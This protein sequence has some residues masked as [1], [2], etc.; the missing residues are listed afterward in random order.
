MNP[1]N[2][3]E[4][5]VIIYKNKNDKYYWKT[6]VESIIVSVCQ[7]EYEKQKVYIVKGHKERWRTTGI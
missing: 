5:L 2:K 4:L 3:E 1:N 7:K 6:S